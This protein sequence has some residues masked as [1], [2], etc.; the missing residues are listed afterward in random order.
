MKFTIA[1]LSMA[2]V[3]GFWAADALAGACCGCSAKAACSATAGTTAAKAEADHGHAHG[4]KTVD[5]GGLKK[6]LDSGEQVV[7]V[8]ARSGKWD[9]GRRIGNASQLAANA[10]KRAIKKALPDKDAQIVAYCT[11]PKCPA[12]KQLAERL[13]EMGYKNVVKYPDGIDGWAAAGNPVNETKQ[14]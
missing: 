3:V 1:T 5:T 8:D 2:L 14:N 10:S 7:V 6:L 11:S 4:Y 12:S 13:V 9:D